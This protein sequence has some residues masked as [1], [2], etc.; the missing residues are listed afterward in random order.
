V[1][2]IAQDKD[3]NTLKDEGNEA[4]KNKNYKEAFEAWA[5][6]LTL[7]D[8][9]GTID[10]A[11]IYNTGYCAYKAKMQK[12][13]IPYF[14]KAI[15]LG[16]KESKPYQMIAVIEYKLDM[17]DEMIEICQ[18]GLETYADDDKLKDYASK[19]YLKKGLEFYNAGNDIKSAA[20]SS[21]LNESDAEAF[22]AEYARA[23]EE[24]KKALPFMK[25][26]YEFDNSNDKAL[27]AL[28]NIYTNLEMTEEA[29][30]AQ[31]KLDAM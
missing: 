31:T 11:L 22:K 3:A 19:A 27:K 28:Q 26:S 5:Q 8:A 24:F 17:I 12:E 21:G 6:A 14:E 16:Y 20:N 13:A 9:E 30:E 29:N 2:L 10:E 7:L 15:E 4:Y 25:K 18:K 23:D 1:N